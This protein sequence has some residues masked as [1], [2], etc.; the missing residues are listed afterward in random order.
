MHNAN[1]DSFQTAPEGRVNGVV[2]ITN[3]NYVRDSF[4]VKVNFIAATSNSILILRGGGNK[5]MYNLVTMHCCLRYHNIS[6]WSTHVG[7]VLC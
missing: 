7:G 5:F 3:G 1:S 2:G 6:L 4:Q